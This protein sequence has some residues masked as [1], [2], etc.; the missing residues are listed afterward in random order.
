MSPPI[1]PSYSLGFSGN[2]LSYLS[3]PVDKNI[4]L[5][6]GRGDFTIE[7][8]QYQTDIHAHP[9][10]F[11]VG[12]YPGAK[13]GVSIESGQ[14]YFWNGSPRGMVYLNDFKNKWLYFAISRISGTTYFFVNNTLVQSFSDSTDYSGFGSNTL[15]I[16]NEMNPTVGSAFGG[17]IYG[18]TWTKGIG[19]YS[20]A[21]PPQIKPQPFYPSTTDPSNLL[22]L[23]GGQFSGV[24]GGNVIN[25]NV[26]SYSEVPDYNHVNITSVTS[27]GIFSATAI[28]QGDPLVYSNITF[29]GTMS[30]DGAF[31]FIDSYFVP[32]PT[33]S[34]YTGPIFFVP[35]YPN[36]INY[37]TVYDFSDV[38]VQV[39]PQT[40]TPTISENPTASNITQY[41]QLCNQCNDHQPGSE[42][43]GGKA[44]NPGTNHQVP[45]KFQFSNEYQY[46]DD[47]GTKTVSVDFIPDDTDTYNTVTFDIEIKVL[48]P[49]PASMVFDAQSSLLLQDHAFEIGNNDFTI[50]WQQYLIDTT[51]EMVYFFLYGDF[52]ASIIDNSFNFITP[53]NTESF[54]LDP[55][56]YVNKW[57]YF[58]ISRKNQYI[59]IFVNGSLFH[60][61][62]NAD[63]IS[64]DP[65]LFYIG[66]GLFNGFMYGFVYNNYEGLYDETNLPQDPK[67]TIPTLPVFNNLD[68]ALVLCGEA[69]GGSA[70]RSQDVLNINVGLNGP[71]PN[72]NSTDIVDDI[73]LW[74]GEH[75][76]NLQDLI[77]KKTPIRV[78]N[79]HDRI[80]NFNNNISCKKI[81]TGLPY[82]AKII[83]K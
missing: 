66:H 22:V 63:N 6:F 17:Y 30:I 57:A 46:M 80:R 45:G 12:T 62:P 64:I 9:R 78:I 81:K 44:V 37:T 75:N 56:L 13:I 24:L 15:T 11:Q 34:Y 53:S 61:F 20:A 71:V 73:T 36:I 8:Q 59:Y 50:E 1:D 67:I 52:G 4:Y 54:Y 83:H 33:D 79:S 68:Y 14:V 35:S 55:E 31:K 29:T 72:Y 70:P 48:P 32:G 40:I 25:T 19:R 69:F 74:N 16:G 41:H 28:T 76:P 3:L 65:P 77:I 58:S 82:V 49:I 18:F 7:W 21:N 47:S 10:P 60:S 26:S 2:A 5:E 42:L 38:T 39:N 51:S 27:P 43:S 23:Y